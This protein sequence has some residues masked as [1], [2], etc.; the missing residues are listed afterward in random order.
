MN[1]DL[2]RQ[3]VLAKLES[4]KTC[5]WYTLSQILNQD[6]KQVWGK[7]KGEITGTKLHDL[8]HNVSRGLLWKFSSYDMDKRILP[9]L[10][11]GLALWSND[12]N[13]RH[14]SASSSASTVYPAEGT[15]RSSSEGKVGSSKSRAKRASA[16][17]RKN[18]MI[19]LELDDFEGSEWEDN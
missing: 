5:D 1:K 6:G 19:G 18:R 8:Y 11:S 3:I 15:I 10:K 7:K 13:E 14:I 12:N 17:K 4:S 16:E 2:V 9:A